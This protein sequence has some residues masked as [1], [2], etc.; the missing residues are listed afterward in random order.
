MKLNSTK[1]PAYPLITCDPYFN[2][3]SMSDTLYKDH[4]RHWT[5][6]QQSMTG[7]IIID[8][9][10][11][12]FMGKMRHNPLYNDCGPRAIEQKKAEVTPLKTIY[13]FSDESIELEVTFMTPLLP[14]DLKLLSRPVSYISYKIKSIDSKKHNC[15]IY[16]DVSAL[17]AVNSPDDTVVFT[18]HNDIL[19]C[20]RGKKD[21]LK[22]SGDNLRIDWGYLHIAAPSG[23]LGITDDLGKIIAY[24][25]NKN[26]DRSFIETEIKVS[27][28]YPVLLIIQS[29]KKIQPAFSASDTTTFIHSNITESMLILI[30]KKT[31]KH[32]PKYFMMQ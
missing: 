1:Y 4:T 8:G 17:M 9:V 15:T 3:W 14:N 31:A 18:K 29:P 22:K 21:M 7:I 2:V 24:R 19:C 25:E 28:E 12:T 26:I 13:T 20:G 10:A 16:M 32:L 27:S 6:S 23:K 30:T 11:K 5:G